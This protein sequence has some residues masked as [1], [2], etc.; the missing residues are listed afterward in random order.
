M[1]VDQWQARG[2]GFKKHDLEVVW[3]HDET[4]ICSTERLW[5]PFSIG[6]CD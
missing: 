6:V 3:K 5:E 4:C 2:L 1:Q